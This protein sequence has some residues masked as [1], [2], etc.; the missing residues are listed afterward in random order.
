M[1]IQIM[2]IYFS[3][4]FGL[5][6]EFLAYKSP[7]PWNFLSSRALGT[8]FFLLYLVFSPQF[9]KR[10]QSH[11]GEMSVLLYVTCPF[12]NSGFMLMKGAFGGY[13]EIR[14]GYQGNQPWSK[15]L[16]I[17]LSLLNFQEG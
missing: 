9:L 12:T 1:V 7:N 17:S 8:F 11:K 2:E 10:L 3:C 6:P 15:G 14:A 5:C 13:L 4:V 16:E